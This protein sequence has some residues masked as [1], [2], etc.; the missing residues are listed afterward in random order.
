MKLDKLIELES[1]IYSQII[2]EIKNPTSTNIIR[3]DDLH[4][5]REEVHEIMKTLTTNLKKEEVV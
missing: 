3:V 1:Q 2:K 4:K 5:A